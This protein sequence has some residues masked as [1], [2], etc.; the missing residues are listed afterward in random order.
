MRIYP[1]PELPD[2]VVEWF[3]EN[4]CL[5]DSD[6]VVVSLSTTDPAVE[7]GRVAAP[8]RDGTVRL[9]D[10]ARVPYHVAVHLED[11][12]GAM[13]SDYD[14]DIDLRDGLNERVSTF[15]DRSR[16]ANFRV[17]WTFDMGA[18]CAALSVTSVV[19]EVSLPGGQRLFFWNAPCESP[20]FVNAIPFPGTFT[21]SARAIAAD[22]VVATSP[23][24]APFNVTLGAI[25]DIGTLTLS[26]CGT[27]C[28]PLDLPRR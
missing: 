8:C 16:D 24:S 1:D 22:G 6:R 9:D 14:A 19:V 20:V 5:E 28:P 17:A 10:V 21:F 25:T 23:P 13:L 3:T 27:T 26:P 4:A 2:V 7:V 18:S 15:F 11:G 12:T